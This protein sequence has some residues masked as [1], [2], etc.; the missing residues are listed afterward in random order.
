MCDVIA[1]HTPLIQAVQ[2]F[3]PSL[4]YMKAY[5]KTEEG[6]GRRKVQTEGE[7]EG[8]EREGKRG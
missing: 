5:L 8:G 2:E 7:R 4:D 3:K 1:T 6:I